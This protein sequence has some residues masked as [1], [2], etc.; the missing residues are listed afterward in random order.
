MAKC[1]A[2]TGSAVKRLNNLVSMPS[3]LVTGATATQNS[4]F[5][6]LAVAVVIAIVLTVPTYG[7]MAE[8]N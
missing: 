8:L 3:V 4:P 1:K 2:L 7:G 5:S 6:S